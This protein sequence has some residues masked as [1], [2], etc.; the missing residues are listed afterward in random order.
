MHLTPGSWPA[1][2]LMSPWKR[3]GLYMAVA[4]R[5]TAG[6]APATATTASKVTSSLQR[7]RIVFRMCAKGKIAMSVLCTVYYR[8]L[9]SSSAAY[10][11]KWYTEGVREVMCGI[12]V[13]SLCLLYIGGGSLSLCTL[14]CLREPFTCCFPLI[15]V[16]RLQ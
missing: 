9:F 2:P 6:V 1:I 7:N 16:F 10:M 12:D 8:I 3:S 13:L 11:L 14:F 4:A 5:G 15:N